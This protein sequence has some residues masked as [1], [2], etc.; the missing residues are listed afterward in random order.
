[1]TLDKLKLRNKA[2]N[3]GSI[4]EDPHADDVAALEDKLNR[5]IE[6]PVYDKSLV[7]DFNGDNSSLTTDQI[8]APDYE[9]ITQGIEQQ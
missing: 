9:E 3:Q 2:V 5:Q 7:Q 8:E 1:L 4:E 6:G